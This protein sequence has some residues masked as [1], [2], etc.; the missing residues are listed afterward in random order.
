MALSKDTDVA[1][2]ALSGCY[3]HDEERWL[4]SKA[5]TSSV[6]PATLWYKRENSHSSYIDS[7]LETSSMS[8]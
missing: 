7:S 3:I 6:F 2:L 1:E 8:S 4:A 5:K